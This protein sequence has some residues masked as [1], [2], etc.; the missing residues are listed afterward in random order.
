MKLLKISALII[1]IDNA[2]CIYIYIYTVVFLVWNNSGVADKSK[3]TVAG[4]YQVPSPA[5]A[6]THEAPPSGETKFKG[7]GFWRGW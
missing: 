2:S 5:I 7:S 3:D 4:P 1:I 6:I